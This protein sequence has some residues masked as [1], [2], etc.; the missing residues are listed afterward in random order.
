MRVSACGMWAWTGTA[1]GIKMD[2]IYLECAD[3]AILDVDMMGVLPHLPYVRP[4][5][6]APP[7]LVT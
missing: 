4:G 1:T 3:L 7:L 6:A 5:Q 2:G